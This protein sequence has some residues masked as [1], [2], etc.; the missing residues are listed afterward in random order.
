MTPIME[1]KRRLP[2]PTLM[3]QLGFGAHANKSALCPFHDDHHNSF[4]IY[5]K[6][7]SW[8]W[9]CHAGC[10]YGDEIDF[11]ELAEKLPRAAAIARFLALAGQSSD[12]P[13][14]VPPPAQART[15]FDWA[16]CISLL[17]Q[18]RL[19]DLASWR[20]YSIKFCQ[21]LKEAGLIGL[22]D[23]QIAF[24][25]HD[26]LGQVIGCHYKKKGK[27]LWKY[28][29]GCH[30]AVLIIGDLS[31]AIRV[32]VFES[33]W[34]AFA[35]CDKLKLHESDTDAILIT[36]GSS[37]TSSIAGRIPK[38]VEAFLWK[39]NDEE[40]DGKIPSED[41]LN[42]VAIHIGKGAKCVITPSEFKDANEWTKRGHAKEQDLRQAIAD[43]T[44]LGPRPS[45]LGEGGH[46]ETRSN[47][48]DQKGRMITLPGGSVTIT[49]SATDLFKRLAPSHS[50]FRR[51]KVAVTLVRNM[52]G[53]LV[54][55]PLRPS[56]ARSFFER[57]ADFFAWRAGK[58]GS[59][60][61]KRVVIPEDTARAFID[62]AAAA[63]LLPVING[64]VNCPVLTETSSGLAV[65]GNGF[66]PLTGIL[67]QK[68]DIPPIVPLDEAIRELRE[69]LAEFRFQSASDEA[70]AIAALITPAMKM[71]NL[72]RGS[73]PIDIGEADQSQSGKTY[74]QKMTA[75]I[76][77]EEPV[78][79]PLKRGGVGSTDESFFAKLVN[80]RPFI[81]FDNYRGAL[82]SPALEAFLTAAGSY[83][84]RIPHC[85]E[86]EVDPSRFFVGLT[87][88]GVE[89][90][91][92][93]ANRAS[94]VRI[95]KRTNVHFPD[96]LG[97]IRNRQ[98]YYLGCVFAIVR[99]WYQNGKCR[100]SETRHDFREW[101]QTLDWIVRNLFG[102]APLMDGH[103]SAQERVSNPAQTF[104]RRIAFEVAHADSLDMPLSAS[105]LFQLAEDADIEIPG[106]REQDQHD[107]DKG[108]KMIGIR[109]APIFKD[110]QVVELDG[111]TVTRAESK[112]QRD[113]DGGDYVVKT[114]TFGRVPQ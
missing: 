21:W 42:G 51:G 109:L 67:V 13:G 97:M 89:T 56:A 91:R 74:L 9:K 16:S 35:V 113:D 54:L 85:Q 76:Y 68:G 34:D 107:A 93:L 31:R 23:G 4:S 30:A 15:R 38:N 86:I 8:R 1:A 24:P 90:T 28:T 112:R 66:N 12:T 44:V 102:M 32:H 57:F 63:D 70:R 83:P 111:F 87:S 50:V 7:D 55:E 45:R 82:D 105:Q 26:S 37:N 62:C 47:P 58:D 2:L 75:A 106:L 103:V 94:I 98:A 71:G 78:L 25:V 10:G 110:N 39:Q 73:I 65:S 101:C 114:Y 6:D 19:E 46:T 69:L 33:Q 52:I 14:S 60:V 72:L 64:L 48:A 41:W 77:N 61:L 99:E 53:D 96:T 22:Y 79:V 5:Q 40:K 17:P 20:A 81:Q 108:K 95:F 43:A 84:C 92:D 80:G 100:T 49:N 3:Q 36:R 11:I 27:R 18:K 88:N 59:P 29:H 104:L